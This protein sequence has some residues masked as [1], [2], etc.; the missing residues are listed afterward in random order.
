MDILKKLLAVSYGLFC[1]MFL[2]VPVKVSTSD[3][4]DFPITRQEYCELAVNAYQSISGE[5]LSAYENPFKDTKDPYVLRAYSVGL[6]DARKTGEFDPNA[7]LTKEEMGVYLSKLVSVLGMKVPNAYVVFTD[8][9]EI[10]DWAK[11]ALKNMYSLGI[12]ETST[13]GE[14]NPKE[15]VSRI[16]TYEMLDRIMQLDFW[17]GVVYSEDDAVENKDGVEEKNGKTIENKQSSR[18]ILVENSDSA[19]KSEIAVKIEKEPDKDVSEVDKVV[20]DSG[21]R[22]VVKDDDTFV[23]DTLSEAASYKFNK[24]IL[25][26]PE[27]YRLQI[28]YTEVN[29]DNDG[30]VTFV[31]H[32]FGSDQYFNPASSIKLGAAIAAIDKINSLGGDIDCLFS[33]NYDSSTL[34]SYIKQIFTYSDN[35]SYNRLYDFLGP[36]EMNESLWEHG[37]STA[38][39]SG[40]LETSVKDGSVPSY[41]IIQNGKIIS[42][43]PERSLDG[44]N[45]NVDESVLNTKVG[46][47]YINEGIKINNPMDFSDKNYASVEDLQKMLIQIFFPETISEE[48]RYNITES[49]VKTIKSAMLKANSEYKYFICGG[50]GSIP[51]GLKIYNKIG[52]AYGFLTDNAYIVDDDGNEFLLTATIYCNSDEVENDG[53]Y[54][55]YSVGFPFLKKLGNLFLD[56]AKKQ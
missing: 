37:F 35:E 29:R 43:E 10:S 53:N 6:I 7:K 33:N 30:K 13:V 47:A 8:H 28:L 26:N 44:L 55:Y 45:L 42:S 50:D 9:H 39:I 40:R 25:E 36:K 34:S 32:K 52:I 15:V 19:G 38:R 2:L 51:D 24:D 16:Q 4:L 22:I 21:Y 46:K 23:K 41:K 56:I 20:R 49:D 14:I 11:E 3:D 12:L 48:Y 1:V 27:E 5:K 54:D 18:E 17:Y 31:S